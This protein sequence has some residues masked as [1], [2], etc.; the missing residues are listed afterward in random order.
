MHRLLVLFSVVAVLAV[1]AACGSDSDD[2]STGSVS[3]SGTSDAA[4]PV[5]LTG[6]TN[7]HGTLDAS[8][9]GDGAEVEMELDDFYFGPTFLKAKAGQKLSLKLKNEG[10]APHTFTTAGGLDEA[11]SP[12]DEKTVQVTALSSGVLVFYCRFHQ[13]QGMQGA[14]YLNEGD[15]VQAGAG[16]GG[17]STTV[18][19]PAYGS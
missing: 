13:G 11:L 7:N 3:A 12:N 16:S 19:A 1:G 4:P 6:T 5:K 14:V 2:D 8:G 9:Q 17:S 15:T 10:S 18:S